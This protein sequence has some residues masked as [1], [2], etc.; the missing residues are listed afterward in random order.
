[1]L[2]LK[3]QNQKLISQIKYLQCTF[4][5]EEE[6][7]RALYGNLGAEAIPNPSRCGYLTKQGKELSEKI[8]FTWL[9]LVHYRWCC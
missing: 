6:L 8:H 1:M 7:A 5:N 9:T 3:Y 4:E 2:E